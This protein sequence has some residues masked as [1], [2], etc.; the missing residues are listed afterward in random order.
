VIVGD[1]YGGGAGLPEMAELGRCNTVFSWSK[2]NGYTSLQLV[3]EIPVRSRNRTRLV[4]VEVQIKALAQDLRTN[5]EH[6]IDDNSPHAIPSLALGPLTQTAH[7]AHRLNRALQ[8]VQGHVMPSVTSNADDGDRN[9]PPGIDL[10]ARAPRRTA[11]MTRPVTTPTTQ[12]TGKAE[13][14]VRPSSTQ[15]CS[16]YAKLASSIPRLQ[17]TFSR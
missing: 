14:R 8:P 4:P 15:S 12:T 5:S 6:T 2:P 1:V 13:A 7:A 11:A 16:A 9:S 3:I 17:P 10:D